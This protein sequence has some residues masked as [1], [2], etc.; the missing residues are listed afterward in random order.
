M[1]IHELK[2]D[3]DEYISIVDDYKTNEVRDN[4]RG[5]KVN[6]YLILNQTVNT[7]EEMKAGRP[8]MYTGNYVLVKVVHIHDNVLVGIKNGWCILSIKILDIETR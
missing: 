3:F 2:I 1:K 6:D 5:Y 4:D 8:L 7:A